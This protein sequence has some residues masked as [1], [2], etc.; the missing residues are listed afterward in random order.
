MVPGMCSSL[1]T[2]R[3]AVLT[4]C[5]ARAFDCC[6]SVRR[7]QVITELERRAIPPPE[8]SE[9]QLLGRGRPVELALGDAGPELAVGD[10]VQ[11]LDIRMTW[12]DAEVVGLRN[13]SSGAATPPMRTRRDARGART[14]VMRPSLS[15][16]GGA[17]H[18]DTRA[19]DAL[20]S[21]P[22]GLLA[23]GRRRW[24][25]RRRPLRCLRTVCCHAAVRELS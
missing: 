7:H 20:P 25:T 17:R 23:R 6:V 5:T 19:A 11:A 15:R 16:L 12:C 4:R 22:A 13:A 8:P 2:A 1:F 21:C 10:V 14:S 18:A 24:R 9:R 3:A